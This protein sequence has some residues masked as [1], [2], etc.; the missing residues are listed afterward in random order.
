MSHPYTVAELALQQLVASQV[1]FFEDNTM[2]SQSIVVTGESGAG[3][4]ENAKIIL[5]YLCGNAD[6]ASSPQGVFQLEDGLVQTN[7]LSEAFGNAKTVRCLP[8]L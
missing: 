7:I 6:P 3:K 5:Q 1:C 8:A 2:P 4:T